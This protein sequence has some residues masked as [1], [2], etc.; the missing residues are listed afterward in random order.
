M[1]VQMLAIELN[2]ATLENALDDLARSLE[3]DER[4]QPRQFARLLEASAGT[5]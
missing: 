4:Y 1:A 5:E 3:D 2:D